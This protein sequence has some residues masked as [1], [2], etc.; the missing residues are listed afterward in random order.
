MNT[1]SRIVSIIFFNR[2]HKFSPERISVVVYS[3]GLLMPLLL[4]ASVVL[5][6]SEAPTYY[7]YRDKPLNLTIDK[8][9]L[10]VAFEA[11]APGTDREV[12]LLKAGLEGALSERTMVKEWYLLT[13]PESLGSV[14]EIYSRIERLTQQPSVA[15]ASPVF[16]GRND[17]W[18]LITP[19]ILLS[20]KEE[21]IFDTDRLLNAL[22]SD[23]KV[24]ESS[25]GGMSG[26]YRLQSDSKNGFNVLARANELAGDR[27]IDWAEPDMQVSVR[28]C[29]IPNDPDFI[30]LWG[31]RNYAQ[32][33]GSVDDVDIDGDLAWD[34]TTGSPDIKI[35]I[36]DN[37]VQQNHPDIHQLPGADL[38]SEG[39]NGGPNNQCDNHGTPVAGCATAIID[40]GI[41]IAGAA[42]NC[43]TLSARV[44]IAQIPC[45]HSS[46][47]QW[48]WVINAL[49][50]GEAQGA[51][52]SNMSWT[53]DYPSSSFEAKLA[54]TY[55][56][57]M[58]HFA[59]VGNDSLQLIH[60]PASLPIVNAIS[61]LNFDGALYNYSN[62][63][64]EV[65]LC[66]P[67]QYVYTTDRTGSDGYDAG[68]YVWY[69]GTSFSSPYAAAV[70]ALVL[71]IEPWL[72]PA[73]VE[74]KLRCTVDDY[75]EPGFDIYYGHGVVNAHKAVS[76]PWVDSDEDGAYDPCDVCPYDP[77]D[78]ADDDGFCGDVDNCPSDYNP[79]QTDTDG[80]DIG[81]VCD[82]CPEHPANDCCNPIGINS[83]PQ[84][85]SPL[86]DSV[87]PDGQQYYYVPAVFDPDC[88]GAELEISFAD[89]PTNLWTIGDTIS[90][91][92][93]CDDV[94][95]SFRIM[96]T[97]GTLAD[98]AEVSIVVLPNVSPSVNRPSDTVLLPLQEYVY[99]PDIIDPDDSMHTIYYALYPNWCIIRND[100][101]IGTAPDGFYTGAV[102]VFVMDHCG[103]DILKFTLV[104]QA[105]GDVDGNGA[106]NLLDITYL[107][108][109]LYMGG[110]PPNPVESGDVN[111]DGVTNIL[112]ITYLIAYLYMGGPEPECL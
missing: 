81:N 64:P 43:Y 80:D 11:A 106:I 61:G 96:V 42:P 97:D 77:Y 66:A 87:R 9:R 93:A 21:Y 40:N 90:G 101:L 38:T 57:G 78:D 52:V 108:S 70:A 84:I 82:I 44:M 62:W 41:G 65:V 50:W 63:G 100:S 95:T 58:V 17:G 59:G 28:S 2:K 8:G 60:Y 112:D 55:S 69:G 111:G 73:E 49:D 76:I 109:Y 25:F 32:F 85:T 20:F 18:A 91:L 67:G 1:R 83:P 56:N 54:S 46:T 6:S 12:A 19:D 3:I 31:I 105:C 13:L 92:F 75:G 98:T 68:D 29:F 94:D 89:I 71:S 72:S 30:N 10:A 86:V 16:S 53:W 45:S 74:Q 102:Q 22:A 15:F 48:S 23:L 36:L 27:H 7:L 35:V 24:L 88:D 14:D 110:L 4:L 99:F 51:R 103:N 39:G 104:V 79:D 107:I 37:G 33:V 26:A 34:I 47:C 5:A